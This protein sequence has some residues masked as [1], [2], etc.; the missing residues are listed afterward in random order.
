M[1]KNN[2]YSYD[3]TQICMAWLYIPYR[4]KYW[5]GKTLANHYKFTKV[6][7][8]I[9]FMHELF[10]MQVVSS[11]SI[12]SIL[13]CYKPVLQLL[14]LLWHGYVICIK[15]KSGMEFDFKSQSPQIKLYEHID[16]LRQTITT[17]T[18]YVSNMSYLVGIL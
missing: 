15:K 10:H 2:Y 14:H 6:W 12:M 1:A 13:K 17:I 11:F 5:W 9:L 3:P 16:L 7:F 18:S 8:V 4:R